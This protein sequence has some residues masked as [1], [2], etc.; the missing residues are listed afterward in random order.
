[1]YSSRNHGA[2][3]DR[4]VLVA[5]ALAALGASG[6]GAGEP[7]IGS[8]VRVDTVGGTAGAN[9]TTTAASDARPHS[10]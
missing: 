5:V 6:A 4:P 8:A 3:V 9:E 10:N 7:S 2:V 1:M